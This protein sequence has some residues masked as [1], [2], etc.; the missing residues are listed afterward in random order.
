MVKR[1]Q[2]FA[3]IHHHDSSHPS[4]IYLGS[5][6]ENL[7]LENFDVKPLHQPPWIISSTL[8]QDFWAIL[9]DC[10]PVGELTDNLSKISKIWGNILKS[11]NLVTLRLHHYTLRWIYIFGYK[12][13]QKQIF[14][15]TKIIHFSYRES[16][17]TKFIETWAFRIIFR[18]HCASLDRFGLSGSIAGRI[19]N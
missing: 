19:R 14:K 12:K 16:I 13:W 9:S 2:Y 17:K 7:F 15:T 4:L 1:I 3:H 6:T 8:V 10:L 18:R 11:G 5:R